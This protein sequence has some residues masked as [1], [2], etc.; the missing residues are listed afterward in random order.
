MVKRRRGAGKVAAD[1]KG[2]EL[3]EVFVNTP[4][5]IEGTERGYSD[6]DE[7]RFV[8]LQEVKRRLGDD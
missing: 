5:L 4:E 8:A 7:G 1:P 3:I 2:Q 6:I